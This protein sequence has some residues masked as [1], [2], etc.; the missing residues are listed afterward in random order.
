MAKKVTWAFIFLNPECDPAVD[1]LEMMHEGN[2]LLIYGTASVEQGMEVAKKIM[3]ED[4][5]VLI[6]LCG[7]YGEDG[8][9]KIIESVDGKIPVGY[10][11]YPT[12]EIP[13]LSILD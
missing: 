11:T 1:K 6:E 13:K 5:C 4:D 12:S 8:A 3:E 2:R 10:V 7:G 9:Q